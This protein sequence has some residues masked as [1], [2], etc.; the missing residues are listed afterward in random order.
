MNIR[1]TAEILGYLAAAWPKYELAEET[2]RVWV[3]QFED[4]SFEH[5]QR[6]AKQIVAKDEWF[7]SVARFR[8]ALGVELRLQPAELGCDRC[9]RGFVLLENGEVTFCSDCRPSA[10]V[11][12]LSSGEPERDGWEQGIGL[13]RQNLAL[14]PADRE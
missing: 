9:E 7:P 11:P 10:Y 13:V 1:E 3:D 14:P 8:A 5:A 2:V 6:A 12:A 4:V